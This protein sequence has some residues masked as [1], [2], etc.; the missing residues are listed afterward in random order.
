M[1]P[2]CTRLIWWRNGAKD[3][4]TSRH[5]LH[6][7]IYCMAPNNVGGGI[8]VKCQEVAAKL[9]F[10][11]PTGV[12]Q[13]RDPKLS[14]WHWCVPGWILIDHINKEKRMKKKSMSFIFPHRERLRAA[15]SSS[16][17]AFFSP[18]VSAAAWFI[19]GPEVLRVGALIP[20]TCVR[21]WQALYLFCS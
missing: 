7:L 8:N 12:I 21:P 13:R 10:C 15:R 16:P 6:S 14:A 11:A 17:P 20:H 9:M 1:Y 5:H 18:D 2:K 3:N 19:Q 4:T